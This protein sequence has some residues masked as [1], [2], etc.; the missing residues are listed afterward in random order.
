M[1]G[2]GSVEFTSY[3]RT[4]QWPVGYMTKGQG[5]IVAVFSLPLFAVAGP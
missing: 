1:A 3:H 5:W 4:G 2:T